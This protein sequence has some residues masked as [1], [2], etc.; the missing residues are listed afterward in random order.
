MFTKYHFVIYQKGGTSGIIRYLYKWLVAGPGFLHPSTAATGCEWLQRQGQ[1]IVIIYESWSRSITADWK[2]LP[3]C[4]GGVGLCKPWDHSPSSISHT[5][6]QLTKTLC[7]CVGSV[8]RPH[9]RRHFQ[10]TH[11]HTRTV[12][13]ES[14]CAVK[15]SSEQKC[16]VFMWKVSAWTHSQCSKCLSSWVCDAL[17]LCRP[18]RKCVCLPEKSSAHYCVFSLSKVWSD[19][20]WD[21]KVIS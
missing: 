18:D 14:T 17:N 20:A 7:E 8:N 12:S 11:T 16:E 21:V 10:S 15:E 9:M 2:S 5:F 3:V 19:C 4:K 1:L 6:D 13:G